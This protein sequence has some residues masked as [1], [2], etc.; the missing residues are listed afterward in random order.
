M[1]KIKEDI[2]SKLNDGTLLEHRYPN[3][4]L[5][6][7]WS[8]D[9]GKK[10]SALANKNIQDNNWLCVGIDDNGH[11]T[12][13]DENWAI[14]TEKTI[15]QHIN[16]YLDPQHACKSVTCHQLNNEWFI[17]IEFNN[18]GAVVKWNREAYKSAGTTI[19]IMTPEEIMGLTVSLPGLEDYSAQ[20]YNGNVED[21][22]IREFAWSISRKDPSGPLSGLESLNCIEVLKRIGI[23]NKNTSRI[24]FGDTKY[25]LVYYDRQGNPIRNEDY[26]GVYKILSENFLTHIQE[27][28][29]EQLGIITNP[30]PGK[31]LKEAL[32]NAV[33]HA[34][35]FDNDG[36]IILELFPEKLV[37]S[38]LC[39]REA[40]YF[41]NRW[42]SR[43]H[44]TYNRIL[45]ETLRLSGYVDELGRGKNLIFSE[46]L[47]YGKTPP[48]VIVERG[49]RFHRWRLLLYGGTKNA[50]HLRL[51]QQLREKY[52]DEQK[53]LLA[54]ALVLWCGKSAS[55]IKEYVEGESE[56]LFIEILKDLNGPVFYWE[57]ND[58]IALRRW[59]K[60]L[61]GEGK[62]TKKLTDAEEKDKLK[63]IKEIQLKYHHGFITPK[64]L[65]DL[66]DLGHTKSAKVMSSNLLKKWEAI[67]EVKRIRHGVYQFIRP[68]TTPPLEVLL[69]LFGIDEKK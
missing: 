61:L 9:C 66:A 45:M 46:S 40:A 16:Q 2:I 17:I 11:L 37:I 18:P 26:Q 28:S 20:E 19:G 24:L 31:A 68:E 54:Q 47:K 30:Y 15:S 59:V 6:S 27:W 42:F 57:S 3:L 69:K 14:T 63:F 33:A 10:I 29:K 51:L 60:I 4:E 13:K 23:Y 67:G 44:K 55:T 39:V 56:H 62:D 49:G 48:Q 12:A 52:K 22:L 53:A 5:K 50:I 1:L 36:E 58:Q 8:Q 64:E 7:S 65:R 21:K 41:A 34:A 38:N 43:A 25:R 35:Y 32:S